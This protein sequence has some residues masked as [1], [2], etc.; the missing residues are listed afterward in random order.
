MGLEVIA[1]EDG[2]EAV[3]LFSERWQSI[4]LVVLDMVMPKMSGRDALAAMRAIDPNIRCLLVSGFSR[5]K[6]PVESPVD[7]PTL[8]FLQKPFRLQAFTDAVDRMLD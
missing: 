6:T 2:A 8:G 3:A 4:N 7:L 1:A 5:E